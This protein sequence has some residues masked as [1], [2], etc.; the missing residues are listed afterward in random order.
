MVS[1]YILLRC[2][3]CARKVLPAVQ[4]G[5]TPEE[6]GM[7]AGIFAAR[8]WAQALDNKVLVNV[9]IRNAYNTISRHACCEVADAIDSDLATWTRWCLASPSMV[10]CNGQ[11]LWCTTG[12]QQGEPL[13]PVLFC[14]GIAINTSRGRLLS[15]SGAAV[16]PG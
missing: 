16:V 10:T 9:D 3:G 14:A 11:N 6:N 5:Y 15:G 8:T 1:K 12:V 13:S 2:G 7:Q 4:L